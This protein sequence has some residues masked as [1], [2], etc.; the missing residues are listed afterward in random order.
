[1]MS[2]AYVQYIRDASILDG[3]VRKVQKPACIKYGWSKSVLPIQNGQHETLEECWS[4][5]LSIVTTKTNSFPLLWYCLTTNRVNK[6]SNTFC[7]VSYNQF[8][9]ISFQQKISMRKLKIYYKNKCY[10]DTAYLNQI[11]TNIFQNIIIFP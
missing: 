2:F 9:G 3:W 8:S 11:I 5:L 6:K 7:S 1:M 10:F 4:T